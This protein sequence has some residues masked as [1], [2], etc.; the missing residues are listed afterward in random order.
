MGCGCMISESLVFLIAPNGV[1]DIA[2]PIRSKPASIIWID[3]DSSK[4]ERV[5]VSVDALQVLNTDV[6]GLEW[7][8]GH[9][10]FVPF[11]TGLTLPNRAILDSID[12]L[13]RHC[14]GYGPNIRIS[15][16][17]I[18]GSEGVG[19]ISLVDLPCNRCDPLQRLKW[20]G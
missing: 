12:H 17:F 15:I 10:D 1:V 7:L 8:I 5:R 9:Y 6:S 19:R 13:N 11:S 3:I 2:V 16:D 18:D 14:H 20:R 4:V